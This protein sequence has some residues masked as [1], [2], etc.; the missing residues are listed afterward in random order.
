GALLA[1]RLSVDVDPQFLRTHGYAFTGTAQWLA[2]LFASYVLGHFIFLVGAALLDDF[3]YDPVRG[4]TCDKQNERR[5]KGEWP[6]PAILRFLARM[7]IKDGA[8]D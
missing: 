8:D 2:F 4:A 6:S 5:A 3:L 7:L 1:W